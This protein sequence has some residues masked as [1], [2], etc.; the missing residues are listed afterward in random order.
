VGQQFIEQLERVVDAKAPRPGTVRD[1]ALQL[2]APV[3]GGARAA[4]HADRGR[5]LARRGEA[6][7]AL[8]PPLS[9]RQSSLREVGREPRV[10]RV[11]E[12]EC[13]SVELEHGAAAGG[14]G[15]GMRGLVAGRR[16]GW[17]LGERGD[18]HRGFTFT[19]SLS[20]SSTIS[21]F[22]FS[23]SSHSHNMHESVLFKA[24]EIN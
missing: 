15:V 13:V 23:F 4:R 11:G 9:V 10:L 2:Q 19:C 24:I 3:T 21:F 16:C 7:A 18:G 12:C 22:F 1:D 6:R 14:G 8:H 20:L 17:A 5:L